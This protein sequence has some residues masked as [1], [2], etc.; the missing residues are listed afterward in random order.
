MKQIGDLV[1]HRRRGD[2]QDTR[3]D[4]GLRERVVAISVGVSEAVGLVNDEQAATGGSRRQG[5]ATVH[6]EGLMRDDRGMAVVSLQQVAPLIHQH[7]R[8]DQ[9]ERLAERAGDRERDVRLAEAD[10]VREQGAA[11]SV[12][13]LSAI[14]WS[15]G[16]CARPW[17]ARARHCAGLEGGSGS[18]RTT[19]ALK[20]RKPPRAGSA[21]SRASAV[22]QRELNSAAN[23]YASSAA[24][25]TMPYTVFSGTTFES[26]TTA[27]SRR[28]S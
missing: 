8:D 23:A 26:G 12:G 16:A 2:E 15:W 28:A 7:S 5:A 24:R 19:R 25:V 6:A 4:H 20:R 11:A 3:T 13:Y 1:V 22:S 10:R 17:S 9:R 18:P 27:A 21:E 14:A